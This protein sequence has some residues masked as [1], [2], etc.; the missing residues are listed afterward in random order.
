[1]TPDAPAPGPRANALWRQ[2]VT[3]LEA[4]IAA[5]VTPPGARLPTEAQLAARFDV[6]RHTVRRA[7]DDLSRRG[8]VRVE[9]GRG[10]FVTQ[11][12]LDYQVAL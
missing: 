7:L 4:D 5:G 9:Q 6:N 10:S 8:R 11:D 2:I 3:A 12:V 1:M